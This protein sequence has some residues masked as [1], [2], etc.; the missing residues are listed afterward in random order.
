MLNQARYLFKMGAVSYQCTYLGPA[1]G[2]RGFEVSAKDG[3]L[4]KTVGR[5]PIPQAFQDGNHVAAS[6]HAKPW[7]RQINI[8]RAYSAFYNPWNLLRVLAS[9]RRGDPLV[10]KKILFQII[11][12]IGLLMTVPKLFTW[13]QKLK[14]GPLETWDG[15]QHAR[16]PMIDAASRLE[17]NWAIEYLPTPNLPKLFAT[18]RP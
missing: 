9:W 2:T 3:T 6:R 5:Q 13:A 10:G 1:V 8:L 18:I 7:Q 16:I 14:R 17:T 4:F 11:G 12:Q 15:L